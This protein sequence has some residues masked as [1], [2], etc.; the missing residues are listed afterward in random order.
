MVDSK[1]SGAESSPETKTPLVDD[2]GMEQGGL[3]VCSAHYRHAQQLYSPNQGVP[4]LHFSDDEHK[5]DT[6]IRYSDV[7]DKNSLLKTYL[8]AHAA[9]SC[10]IVDRI[11]T[12]LEK[13]DVNSTA[14]LL[15][16]FQ[17]RPT[18]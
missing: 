14:D 18:T 17:Y 4:D 9:W 2:R 1:P 15:Q 7:V 6:Q 5:V 16:S 11:L 8:A 12:H 10:S 3:W 13:I